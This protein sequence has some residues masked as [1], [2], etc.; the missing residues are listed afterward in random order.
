MIEE[1][2]ENYF[3]AEGISHKFHCFTDAT[4]LQ[5]YDFLMNSVMTVKEA[6]QIVSNFLNRY[7][8]GCGLYIVNEFIH[9]NPNAT[10]GYISDSSKSV[11]DFNCNVNS[12]PYVAVVL[13]D[14]NW[15]VYD[16]IKTI[17]YMVNGT[18]EDAYSFYC[19]IP[20]REY[21]NTTLLNNEVFTVLPNPSKCYKMNIQDYLFNNPSK[22]EFSE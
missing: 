18:F 1:A 10:F 12:M 19:N 15:F 3:I 21:C 11:S 16:I 22:K 13:I 7:K 8:K 6:L 14:G 5:H 20:I 9:N 4:I 17:N 2:L